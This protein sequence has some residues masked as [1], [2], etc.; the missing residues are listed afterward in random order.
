MAVRI[1]KAFGFKADELMALQES[2]EKF[3]A[4]A[5]Q[6][7]IAVRSYAPSFHDIKALQINA[8]ADHIDARAELAVLLRK[9]VRSTAKGLTLA[10]FPAYEN[11]QRP[12]WD[13]RVGSDSATPW[14]PQGMSGWEFGV[15]RDPGQKANSD[16]NFRTV[17]VDSD[18]RAEICFI[19]VTPRNWPGKTAWLAKKRVL[20][21]WKD[22]RAYDASDLEQ[23]L[24]ESIPAQAWIAHRLHLRANGI[25]S[26][27]DQ[28]AQWADVTKPPMAKD[29]FRPIA[30]FGARKLAD[31]L[32]RAPDVP[33]TVVADSVGEALAAL[34]CSFES[35][36]LVANDARDRAIV[37]RSA[38]ALSIAK[39]ASSDFIAILASDEAERASAGLH[40]TQ[41]TIVVTRRNAIEGNADLTVDL[42]DSDAFRESLAAMGFD[43]DASE[44]L[45][46]ESGQSQTVLRRRLA[47]L[48][49]IQ[50]PPWAARPEVAK[51]LIPM[52]LVGAWDA[53]VHADQAI[54]S[55]LA[56]RPY[57]AI[58]RAVAELA[59]EE[60][61]PV[62]SVGQARGL[63]SKTDAF[64]AIR[65][66]VT[67][68]DLN[69]F[70]KVA[71][72]VLSET[73][74]AL[75]LPMEKRW[76]SRLFGKSRQHSGIL[77][78][79][80]CETLVLLAVHGENLFGFRLGLSVEANVNTLI[81]TLLTPFDAQTWQ[82]QRNNLPDYAEAAPD[83][84]LRIIEADL[85][86]PAPTLFALMEPADSGVFS[87]PARSGS[88]W[89]LER[90]AWNPKW[91]FR[92]VKVLGR[93]SEVHVKDNW[94]NKPENSLACIF[95]F[96]LP[97][98]AATLDQRI[99]ALDLLVRNS[100]SVGW[101]I[102][103]RQFDP[104]ET[105]GRYNARPTWRRDAAGVGYG[106]PSDEAYLMLRRAVDVAI[107]WQSHNERTL[108]D[109]IGCLS[110]IPEDQDSVWDAV[111][112]WIAGNPDNTAKS[113][114]RERIRQST[115]T[116]AG[117]RRA[118]G[119]TA[120]SRAREAYDLLTP[121]DIVLR[122]LWLFAEH[123]VRE[124]PDELDDEHMDYE[125]RQKRIDDLRESALAEIWRLAGFDGLVRLCDA[126]GVA[127]VVGWHL[128]AAVFDEEQAVDFA[129]SLARFDNVRACRNRDQCLAGFLARLEPLVRQRILQAS[130]ES[131]SKQDAADQEWALR[132]I[133]LSPANAETWRFADSIP[134]PLRKRYWAEMVPPHFFRENGTDVNRL[135][136]ELLQSQ[137]PRAAFNAVEM[138]FAKVTSD[139]IIRLLLD[140]ATSQQ[141]PA[142][143]YQ[144]S[145]H[146][147]SDAFKELSLR[148][149]VKPDD[150]AGLEF[151]YID[152]LA[153]TEHG[154]KNLERQLS[155]LPELFVKALAIAFKRNDG[156]EDP[157]EL[158]S[159]SQDNARGA[160]GAAYELLTR[161]KRLPGTN[162]HGGI[163]AG[164][165][166]WWL[167]QARALS[168]QNAR[169]D[170]ADSVI[171]QYLGRS[172]NGADGIWPHE[173]VREVIED[174]GT[175]KMAN[176][177]AIGRYN[178]RG[179]VWRK[180][181]G[182]QERE[183]AAKYQTW[184]ARLASRYPFTAGVLDG[185]ARM[186]DRDAMREDTASKAEERLRH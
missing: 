12:G 52:M 139:R 7:A 113:M 150:L 136:D 98:T 156:R 13:G 152:A 103:L 174:I 170:V 176:G 102:A 147:I 45:A 121:S 159:G 23:W 70:F 124:S 125:K 90:L 78:R 32:G 101:R 128:A 68:A 160:A 185:L 153:Y 133:R 137:R 134:A 96:W 97:Q 40:R 20:A 3:A 175:A 69:S 76:A 34:V 157:P 93:L 120:P 89:A 8:W 86:S 99:D 177:M 126:S 15:D 110:N 51:R 164:R 21:D 11:S 132:L 143:H 154:I 87:S 178:T 10:D 33:F 84:F 111:S 165:L 49:A 117:I 48:P 88:L 37:L 92:V 145:S 39:S 46:R 158:R 58:E 100:P 85:Q 167:T 148:P 186:Y 80:L 104:S 16:Y 38:D 59:C 50:S 155:E 18:E 119:T 62:W 54:L 27:D 61:S 81:E 173:A 149:D 42:V 72:I 82:S 5:R 146:D 179:V 28:W 17:A 182:D 169:A 53:T 161:I 183:L 83:V 122:H 163:D 180:K 55:D 64:Y 73:D 9:L 94:V 114:L 30:A 56:C 109:L 118:G 19:F 35:G 47:M 2:H 79:A 131:L 91:F 71:R 31:W 67:A 130:A 29:L 63:V 66:L 36:D 151:L 105:I 162:D 65:Q 135:V 184:S 25:E 127:H 138:I 144:L 107:S 44:R 142:G 43:A 140:C 75:D 168:A 166:R 129:T 4:K 1:E 24:E 95:R 171:G 115:M 172:P 14:I 108:G 6:S 123:W 106:V 116:V 22:V 77:R 41:H 181:G 74:P 112:K 141:E 26:L 60:D 57:D